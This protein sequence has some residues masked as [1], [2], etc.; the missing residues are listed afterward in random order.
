MLNDLAIWLLD[1]AAYMPAY[2][3]IGVFLLAAVIA[4]FFGRTEHVLERVPF[5]LMSCLVV[6]MISTTSLLYTDILSPLA[7]G[8]LWTLLIVQLFVH[9]AGGFLLSRA[10]VARSRDAYRHGRWAILAF[11]PVAYF[12]LLLKRPTD[13][14]ASN[15][16]FATSLVKGIPGVLAASLLLLASFMVTS[17]AQHA[18]ARMEKDPATQQAALAAILRTRGVDEVLRSIAAET[19]IPAKTGEVTMVA[20]EAHGSELRRTYVMD[21]EGIEL[22]RNFRFYLVREYCT[23]GRFVTLLEAGATLRQIYTAP[24]GSALAVITI[25]ADDCRS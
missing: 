4:A 12:W 2:L 20:I 19:G 22:D 23:D 17:Y 16:M 14:S 1:Q 5:F 6:F 13:P 25:T 15:R 24:D 18:A 21:V 3:A 9:F 10:A 7:G 8:Y 11:V